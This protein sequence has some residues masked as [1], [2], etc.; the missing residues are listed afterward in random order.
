MA[1]RPD[2]SFKIH[3]V[4]WSMFVAVFSFAFLTPVL[5]FCIAL[6]FFSPTCHSFQINRGKNEKK[7]RVKLSQQWWKRSVEN[8][9]DSILLHW[10]CNLIRIHSDRFIMQRPTTA[11]TTNTENQRQKLQI[12]IWF[13]YFVIASALWIIEEQWIFVFILCAEIGVTEQIIHFSYTMKL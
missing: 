13:L 5:F 9:F 1:R 12:A 7:T 6:F 4:C 11:Y 10:K 2:V 3:F 8:V